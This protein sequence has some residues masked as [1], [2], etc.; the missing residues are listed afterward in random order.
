VDNVTN[1]LTFGL[2]L[3]IPIGNVFR[4]L[5]LGGNVR[6]VGCRD[7]MPTPPMSIYAYGGPILYLAIQVV[8][9]LLIIIW[10]EGD[11]AFFRRKGFK[12]AASASTWKDSEKTGSSARNMDVEEERQRV[13]EADDDLLRVLSV[14]KSFGSNHAVQNVSLGLP[15]SDVM[16]LLGPNGAGKSTLVNMI[17][18]ELSPEHGRILLKG[19]DA[20]TR[21]AQRFLGSTNPLI[22]TLRNENGC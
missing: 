2:N 1:G 3:V 19:E 15:S 21:S 18:S 17:Q 11:L 8:A 10:I 5:L 12:A 14:D 9:L 20:R 16:A 13:E 6:Q 7:G 4:A 22:H